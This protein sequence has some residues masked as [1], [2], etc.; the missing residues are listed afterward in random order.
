MTI[1]KLLKLPTEDL[2]KMTNEELT[3]HLA[4]Y[5]PITWSAKKLTAEDLLPPEVAA[6]V[7]QATE[8]KRTGMK[9]KK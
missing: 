4:Q 7:R 1:E 6:M 3:R 2:E 8:N 9:L 5:F